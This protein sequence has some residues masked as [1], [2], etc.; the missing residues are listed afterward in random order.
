MIDVDSFHEIATSLTRHKLRTAL[1]A[2]GVFFGLT[3]FMLMVSFGGSLRSGI[4]KKMSGFATNAVFLWGQRTSEP[5]AGLPAN[6]PG[7]TYRIVLP[8]KV[9]FLS[10][11]SEPT[12]RITSIPNSSKL[13]MAPRNQLSACHGKTSRVRNIFF[14]PGSGL[15]LLL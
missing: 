10:S 6:R 8:D 12:N 4:S 2:L 13:A 15:Y 9:A 14:M 1:T 5:Y 7:S 11:S 3:I